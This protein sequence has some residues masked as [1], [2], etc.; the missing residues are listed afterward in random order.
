MDYYDKSYDRV[1]TK[2]ERQLQ[3]INRTYA[4]VTTT[5]DPVIEKVWI[6]K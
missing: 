5:D 1:S 3:R 4:L 2:N 6:N